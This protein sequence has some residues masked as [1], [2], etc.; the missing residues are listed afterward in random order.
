MVAQVSLID[1]GL[2]YRLRSSLLFSGSFSR[3]GNFAP[4]TFMTCSEDS[5]QDPRE[6]SLD[7]RLMHLL[8]VS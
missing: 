4:T 5:V 8:T 7:L 2:P 3:N 6:T 1:Q